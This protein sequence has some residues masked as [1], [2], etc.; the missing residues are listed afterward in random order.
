[1]MAKR[2]C[3]HCGGALRRERLHEYRDPLLGLDG[4]VIVDA[5]VETRC[6]D[7]GR[8]ASHTF[9]NLE[10]LLAAAA[11][12]RVMQPEKLSGKDIRFLRKLLDW[13]AKALAKRVGVR[14][15][16]VSRWENGKE[17]INVPAEKFLR[18]VVGLHLR[19]IAPL[20]D[21]DTEA[22]ETMEIVP[23]HSADHRVGLRLRYM[24]ADKAEHGH[25][26][27]HLGRAA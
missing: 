11:T 18:T 6:A 3:E 19:D 5:V 13:P 7:C 1:M 9:P 4:V 17:A 15:E 21:F 16:T 12:A 26:A 25:G 2:V 20:A 14:E 27:W 23:V 10:G 8:V 22:I 24:R